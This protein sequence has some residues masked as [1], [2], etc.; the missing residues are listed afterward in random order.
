MSAQE[1]PAVFLDFPVF[2]TAPESLMTV[3]PLGK[4]I[5]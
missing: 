3:T 1:V 4:G 5:P 2:F